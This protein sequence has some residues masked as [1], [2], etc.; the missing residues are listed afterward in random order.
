MGTWIRTISVFLAAPLRPRLALFGQSRLCFRV[1]PGDL[2][3]NIHMNN[4]RYLA[5]MDIGRID[6]ILRTGMWRAM[7]A[8]RWQAVLAGSL[9]RYRRSLKPFQKLEL[10][11]RLIGWDQKWFYIEHRIESGGLAACQ[12]MVR[13]A[14]LGA[15][16]IIAPSCLAAAVGHADNS[17]GLPNW[18]TAWNDA[19]CAM[20]QGPALAMVEA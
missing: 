10:T 16:G 13:G 17:P 1:L 2:D 6:L 18:V 12:T 8:N 15:G 4:A 7:W 19:D 11:S 14:F 5:L 9:V 20:D 3:L